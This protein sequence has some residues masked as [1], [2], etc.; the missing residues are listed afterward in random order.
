MSRICKIVTFYRLFLRGL[1]VLVAM[2][3]YVV[4]VIAMFRPA[5]PPMQWAPGS[6]PRGKARPGRDADHSPPSSAVIKNE[7]GLYFLFPLAPA[8]RVGGHVLY[9]TCYCSTEN[10]VSRHALSGEYISQI[11]QIIL[12]YKKII[13]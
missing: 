9:F 1:Y 12:K 5:H 7:K 8:W 4:H 10:F 6:F 2:E 11:A 13:P 3:I